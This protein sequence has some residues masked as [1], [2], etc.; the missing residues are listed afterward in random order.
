M[1]ILGDRDTQVTGDS[2]VKVTV[3]DEDD[4]MHA[5]YPFSVS[6]L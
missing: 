1:V 5:S 6:F 2:E 4:E 3:C